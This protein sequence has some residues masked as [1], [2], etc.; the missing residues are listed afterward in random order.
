M[1]ENKM[2]P[3][4]LTNKELVNFSQ[5]LA[6]EQKLPQSFQLELIKRLAQKL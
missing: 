3:L 4:A 5:R 1:R 6:H 2:N